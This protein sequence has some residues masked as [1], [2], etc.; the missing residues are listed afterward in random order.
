MCTYRAFQ[1]LLVPLLPGIKAALES[2]QLQV[3]QRLHHLRPGFSMGS[4][5]VNGRKAGININ[6]HFSTR[7]IN[8]IKNSRI[9]YLYI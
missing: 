5:R 4:S 1:S 2:L 9:N 6:F 8:R 7:S 3:L